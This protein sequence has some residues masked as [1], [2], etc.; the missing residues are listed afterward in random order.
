MAVWFKRGEA[1]LTPPGYSPRIFLSTRFED[2]FNEVY[3]PTHHEFK[4]TLV[5]ETHRFLT[6]VCMWGGSDKNWNGYLGYEIPSE[7]YDAVCAAMRNRLG[8]PMSSGEI[9]ATL[10]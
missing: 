10:A 9:V 3:S 8:E 7:R 6:D 1:H 5:C 4:P 2:C